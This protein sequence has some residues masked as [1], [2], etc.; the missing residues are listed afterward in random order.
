MHKLFTQFRQ[1]QTFSKSVVTRCEPVQATLF[2]PPFAV[3][4]KMSNIFEMH[5]YVECVSTLL[6][7]TEVTFYLYLFLLSCMLSHRAETRVFSFVTRGRFSAKGTG[8]GFFPSS[9]I[10]R[11][12][13]ASWHSPS[14]LYSCS[15]IYGSRYIVQ[16]LTALLNQPH[17]VHAVCF[18][19]F[20]PL[21]SIWLF[22]RSL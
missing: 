20:Y 8:K 17:A 10:Y 16:I 6:L 11:I 22:V 21:C 2:R 4:F 18:P 13:C 7:V 15:L 12:F 5:R 3:Y 19:V 9:S 14:L 1:Q